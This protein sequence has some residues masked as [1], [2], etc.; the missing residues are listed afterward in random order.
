MRLFNKVESLVSIRKGKDKH[1][2]LVLSCNLKAA[3]VT[4]TVYNLNGVCCDQLMKNYQQLCSSPQLHTTFLTVLAHCFRFYTQDL[5]VWAQSQGS[6]QPG[7]QK[8]P[9]AVFFRVGRDQK[10]TYSRC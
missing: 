1:Q 2:V 3:L 7:I 6:H 4:V 10:L 8:Q 9:A 5:T